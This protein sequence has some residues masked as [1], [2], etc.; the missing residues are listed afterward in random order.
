VGHVL[1]SRP[2]C[3]HLIAS[4]QRQKRTGSVSRVQRFFITF[5]DVASGSTRHQCVYLRCN[6]E[7]SL[8]QAAAAAAN[9]YGVAAAVPY[10]PHC[11][12][13]YSDIAPEERCAPTYQCTYLCAPMPLCRRDVR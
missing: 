3:K 6:K 10:D 12:L 7:R 4:H 13:L 2:L 9:V 1:G 11:S 8:L 5:A